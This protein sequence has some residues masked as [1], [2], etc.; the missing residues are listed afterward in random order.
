MLYLTVIRLSIVS[1]DPFLCPVTWLPFNHDILTGNPSAI[2]IVPRIPD[3]FID[4]WHP[5]PPWLT[6]SRRWGRG[7][8]IVCMALNHCHSF[9]LPAVSYSASQHTGAQ[10]YNSGLPIIPISTPVMAIGKYCIYSKKQ[11]KN[12]HR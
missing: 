1:I 3:S 10:A 8:L 11:G 4:R 6:V 2:F 9:G 5:Y 12:H 7:R